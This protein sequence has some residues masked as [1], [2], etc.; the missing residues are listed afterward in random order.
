MSRQ[1]AGA[2]VGRVLGGLEARRGRCPC[3]W[4][5][6]WAGVG[7]PTWLPRGSGWVPELEL[8]VPSLRMGP[9]EDPASR[10]GSSELHGFWLGAGHG[11]AVTGPRGGCGCLESGASGMEGRGWRGERAGPGPAASKPCSSHGPAPAEFK[12]GPRRGCG[13]VMRLLI[14]PASWCCRAE[15]REAGSP[16][17]GLSGP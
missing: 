16:G 2:G 7:D 12:A 4:A 8:A 9:G 6:A 15:Q 5:Q 17:M 13:A 1:Q 11:A 3:E 14:Q 10:A